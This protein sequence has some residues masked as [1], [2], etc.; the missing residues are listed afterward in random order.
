[1][2]NE[3][4]K[5]P[6]PFYPFHSIWKG[7]SIAREDWHFHIRLWERYGIVLRPGEYTR[8]YD[9][10]VVKKMKPIVVTH[11][12]RIHPVFLYGPQETIYVVANDRHLVTVLTPSQAY[13]SRTK[14]LAKLARDDV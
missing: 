2:S 9:K 13:T 7:A 4:N 11:R 3:R 8:I 10:A 1:M 5:K 12:G 14:Y 6:P